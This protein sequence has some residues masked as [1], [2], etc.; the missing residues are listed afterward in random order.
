MIV[1]RLQKKIEEMPMT[2]WSGSANGL[3]YYDEGTLRLGFNVPTEDRALLYSII[4]EIC[5]YR[6]HWYFERKGYSKR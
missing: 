2:K 6:L 3:L 4:K 5:D 1:L